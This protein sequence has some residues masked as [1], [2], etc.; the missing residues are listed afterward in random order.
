MGMISISVTAVILIRRATETNETSMKRT[1]N[2]HGNKKEMNP[3]KVWT[4]FDKIVFIHK[5]I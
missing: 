4:L 2:F 3:E 1:N 5:N